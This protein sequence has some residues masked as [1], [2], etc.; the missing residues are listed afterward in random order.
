[1]ADDELQNIG[2][3]IA[4]TAVMLSHLLN[5]ATFNTWIIIPPEPLVHMTKVRNNKKDL[6]E[7][8]NYMERV[9]TTDELRE[10]WKFCAKVVDRLMFILLNLVLLLT[11]VATVLVNIIIH[12]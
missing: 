4:Y 1:M 2:K 12:N 11:F 9:Y 5:W 10:C 7:S 3:K 8:S 6:T